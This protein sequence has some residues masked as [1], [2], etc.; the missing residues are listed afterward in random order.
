MANLGGYSPGARKDCLRPCIQP[1]PQTPCFCGHV[2]AD[3][4]PELKSDPSE[5]GWERCRKG[6]DCARF[7]YVRPGSLCSCGHGSLEHSAK[8]FFACEVSECTCQTFHDVGTCDVCSHDWVSHRTELRFSVPPPSRRDAS[9][10]PESSSS[11]MIF[12]KRPNSARAEKPGAGGAGGAG[13][14]GAPALAREAA[15]EKRP[16]GDQSERPLSAR[17]GVGARIYGALSGRMPGVAAMLPA[18]QRPESAARDVARRPETARMR[19]RPETPRSAPGPAVPP[20]PAM[21][22]E[23]RTRPETPNLR[24]KTPRSYGPKREDREMRSPVVSPDASPAESASGRVLHSP[25]PAS[26]QRGASF[27]SDTSWVHGRGAVRAHAPRGFHEPKVSFAPHRERG[28]RWA[29]PT[30]ASVI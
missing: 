12:L 24:P 20:A 30:V 26:P 18:P 21:A 14:V 19:M 11:E 23:T 5:D 17:N 25:D 27:G 10:S 29:H 15:R 3:H 4:R 8:G 2:L 7:S 6:C 9:E 28:G 16:L 13:G 1:S 22:A